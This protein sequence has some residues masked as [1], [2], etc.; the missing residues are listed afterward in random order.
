MKF[1]L[2]SHLEL[3]FLALMIGLV[4]SA[5]SVCVI[6]YLDWRLLPVVHVDDAGTCIKVENFE[7]GHAFNCED[8]DVILR[9]YRTPHEAI[10]K[11]G[12]YSL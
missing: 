5:L 8:V 6:L 9:R 3:F 12:L 7:N 1:N 10:S 4:S 11:T 2:I